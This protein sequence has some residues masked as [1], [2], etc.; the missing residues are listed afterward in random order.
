M[1][2]S[3]TNQLQRATN[4]KAR[5]EFLY[6]VDKATDVP[7]GQDGWH[8]VDGI[9]IADRRRRCSLH[10]VRNVPARHCRTHFN[11]FLFHRFGHWET[12]TDQRRTASRSVAGL[13]SFHSDSRHSNVFLGSSSG[14]VQLPSTRSWCPGGDCT[15]PSVCFLFQLTHRL[16]GPPGEFQRNFV[17]FKRFQFL[18]FFCYKQT[19]SRYLVVTPP[20]YSSPPRC[21]FRQNI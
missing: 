5:P 8:F 11:E 6:H 10:L 12:R 7:D 16:P 4:F 17:S 9:P 2:W 20:P 14:S 19:G 21:L 3:T 1:V 13:M 18:S 15:C